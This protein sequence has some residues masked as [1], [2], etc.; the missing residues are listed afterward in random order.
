M[1][2][3]ILQML[4]QAQPNAETWQVSAILPA[5]KISSDA[6]RKSTFAAQAANNNLEGALQT[7]ARV[8]PFQVLRT[9]SALDPEKTTG[10]S[11]P[12][13]NPPKTQVAAA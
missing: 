1:D 10:R 4:Q 3:A 12:E 7:E 9:V 2:R 11:H 8:L 6:R 5:P 13:T